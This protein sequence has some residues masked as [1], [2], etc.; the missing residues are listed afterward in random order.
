MTTISVYSLRARERPTVSTPVRW[1]EVE[2]AL[3][4]K[5]AALL[6]FES[7]QVLSRVE[8]IGDLFAPVLTLKQKLPKLAGI[9]EMEPEP[10]EGLELAA[11]AEEP[12]VKHTK[13]ARRPG[14][15]LKK[16]AR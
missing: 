11:Q 3:K 7:A 15:A 14:S 12:V 9:K 16:K 10:A 13:K 4:K 6:V 5:N 8:K 1:D 2:H